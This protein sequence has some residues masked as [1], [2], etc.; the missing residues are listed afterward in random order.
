MTSATHAVPTCAVPAERPLACPWCGQLHTRVPLQPGDVS[1]CVRCEAQIGQGRASDW[2]VTLAW[3]L[4][5]LILW[6]PANLLPI[7]ALSRLGSNRESLL[8]TGAV[9]LWQQGMPWVAALVVL[10]GIVAPLLVLLALAALLG[11]IVLGRTMPRL[12]RL[13]GWLRVFELWS[14]PEVYLL[15]VLVAFIKLGTVVEAMPAT[16]LWCHAAMAV[17]LLIA[18]RRFDFD[19]ATEALTAGQPREVT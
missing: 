5:G 6:V 9:G 19:A 7:V 15:G 2:I 18:W 13:T 4:T 10:T 16:G 1:Q 11:P 3:A 17:A 12:A 8:F 14:L